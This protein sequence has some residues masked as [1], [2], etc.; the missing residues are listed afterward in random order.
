MNT[1]K[2]TLRKT[3]WITAVISL[4]GCIH[5]PAFALKDEK[6][7]LPTIMVIDQNGMQRDFYNDL[8][9]DKIVAINFIFTKCT[10]ICP[11]LGYQF[12]QLQRA[13]P[14][15]LIAPASKM[16]GAPAQSTATPMV[17]LISISTDP[18]ND[19]PERLLAWSSQFKTDATDKSE[20]NWTLV[21]GSKREIDA[22]L[23]SLNSFAADIN[24]HSSLVII[25]ND[26]LNQWTKIEGTSSSRIMLEALQP[27][28]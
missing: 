11:M 15:G 27:W 22:L 23:K 21:T 16:Q 1:N 5:Q 10:M 12:G 14:T 26:K 17:H 20:D 7:L 25:G 18:L 8:I 24:E 28:L 9:K 19:T 13:L 3:L 4:L 2:K 6:L